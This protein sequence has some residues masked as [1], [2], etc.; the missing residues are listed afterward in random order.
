MFSEFYVTSSK[1]TKIAAGIAFVFLCLILLPLF[2]IAHFNYPCT[3]DFAFARMLYREINNGSSFKEVILGAWEGF[4]SF[5]Q[6]LFPVLF[7]FCYLSLLESL[8]GLI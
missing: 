6:L 4:I 2:I 7:A 1:Q 3:D 5:P 8:Y